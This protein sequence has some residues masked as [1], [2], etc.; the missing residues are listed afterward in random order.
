MSLLERMEGKDYDDRS[1]GEQLRDLNVEVIRTKPAPAITGVRW[2]R[3]GKQKK[4]KQNAPWANVSEKFISFN[5][6]TVALMDG[7]PGYYSFGAGD[8]QGRRVLLIRP[9]ERGYK[10][11]PD[12]R[13]NGGM[14]NSP[15]LI[16]QLLAGG[17]KP[18]R[19]LL[20]KVKGGWMGVPE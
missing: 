8:F 5:T 6:A 11:T 19:Y 9:A 16:R 7:Y 20:Q 1:V 10:I 2:A 12:L 3:K 14:S 18:G 17:L 13:G 4:Q 15:S